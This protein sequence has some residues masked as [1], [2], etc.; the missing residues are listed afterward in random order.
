[1]ESAQRAPARQP[2]GRGRSYRVT[3][4]RN[5]PST[6][7]TLPRPM[8]SATTR[9]WTGDNPAARDHGSKKSHGYWGRRGFNGR[10]PAVCNTFA[11]PGSQVS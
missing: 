4:G 1:M 2:G 3:G 11:A 10:N 9:E 5:E 6:G 7:C 8:P